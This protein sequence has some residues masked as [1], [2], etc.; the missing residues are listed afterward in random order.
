MTVHNMESE[1]CSHPWSR[2]TFNTSSPRQSGLFDQLL[3]IEATGTPVSSYR[4]TSSLS[5]LL[6][7][8]LKTSYRYI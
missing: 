2:I 8:S 3:L 6:Q 1:S 7:I 5:S 4:T